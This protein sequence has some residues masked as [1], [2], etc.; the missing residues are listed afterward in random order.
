MTR[1]TGN[2]F[3]AS[4]EPKVPMTWYFRTGGDDEKNVSGKQV[5]CSNK[6]K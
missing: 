6:K 5:Q 4:I 1:P 2:A 3:Q